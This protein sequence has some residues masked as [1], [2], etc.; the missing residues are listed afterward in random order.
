MK[1]SMGLGLMV[2]SACGSNFP[3]TFEATD[4][5][6][7]AFQVTDT[8]IIATLDGVPTTLAL[9]T[10]YDRGAFLGAS[11][12]DGDGV[13]QIFALGQTDN[14]YAAILIDTESTEPDQL[15]IARTADFDIQAGTAEL[16]GTYVGSLRASE[17][18]TPDHT[19]EENSY[20]GYTAGD[21]SLTV[22]FDDLTVAGEI[23]NR[24]VVIPGLSGID[25]NLDANPLTL[26]ATRLDRQGRFS[27]QIG[28]DAIVVEDADFVAPE[29]ATFTGLIGGG[30]TVEAVGTIQFGSETGVF[31]VSE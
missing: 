18:N 7:V 6:A 27:G 12:S 13:S 29:T 9:D 3:T 28:T 25:F 21:A 19:D 31:S 15:F 1:Y 14:T 10:T 8:D 4:T 26:E 16:T 11:E 30:E 20:V 5:D 2:L 23:T 24:T 22:S 17:E